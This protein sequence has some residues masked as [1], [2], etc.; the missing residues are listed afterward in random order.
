M[1]EAVTLLPC[2]HCGVVNAVAQCA[3]CGRQFVITTDHL[4]VVPRSW[5]AQAVQEVPV[6]FT[7]PLCDYC[8]AKAE[9]DL[10]AAVNAGL[11]QRTC[12]SCRQ[13]FLPAKG[14]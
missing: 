4:Q 5:D 10:A 7:V 6:G 12:P 8:A 3:Q 13:A 2:G 11:R 9:R 1:A 14:E